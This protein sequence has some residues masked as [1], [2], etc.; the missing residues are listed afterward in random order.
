MLRDPGT[1]DAFREAPD[2]EI[3]KSGK[4]ATRCPTQAAGFHWRHAEASVGEK[5]RLHSNPLIGRRS[6]SDTWNL[7][8]PVRKV[9]FELLQFMLIS[10]RV[11]SKPETL[12][13]FKTEIELCR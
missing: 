8:D 5:S 9:E 1:R 6:V 10:P 11:S 3:G 12:D 13:R 2:R 7:V 4:S